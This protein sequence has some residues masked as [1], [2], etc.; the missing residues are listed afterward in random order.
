V[1]LTSINGNDGTADITLNAKKY[2]LQLGEWEIDLNYQLFD[3]SN[4][5]NEG[6][7]VEESGAMQAGFRYAGTMKKG[8]SGVTGSADA[9]DMLPPSQGTTAVFQASS[10]CSITMAINHTRLMLRRTA[11]QTG[12]VQG[13]GRSTG[14][15]TFAWVRA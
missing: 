7:I 9:M 4:F 12:V 13:E 6:S 2:A 14:A 1:P 8:A 5:A 15:I 11:N 10:G 3:S